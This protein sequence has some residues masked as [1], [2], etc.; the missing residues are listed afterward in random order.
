MGIGVSGSSRRLIFC[1]NTAFAWGT[2]EIHKSVSTVWLPAE[3]R[4]QHLLVA[5]Q[6]RHRLGHLPRLNPQRAEVG[7]SVCIWAIFIVS[8]QCSVNRTRYPVL[9]E[10]LCDVKIAQYTPS[11][12]PVL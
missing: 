7:S 12:T 8:L 4:P 5:I 9:G 6:K 1:I 2:L 11:P 10:A 3:F